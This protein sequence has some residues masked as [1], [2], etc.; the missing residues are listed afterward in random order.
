M[1]LESIAAWE[2]NY[3]DVPFGSTWAL[4][5]EQLFD[6]PD[7][8]PIQHNKIELAG[9]LSLVD[10]P[11]FPTDN[12]TPEDALDFYLTRPMSL[13]GQTIGGSAN[14]TLQFRRDATH[15]TTENDRFVTDTTI[16]SC[17]APNRAVGY[18]IVGTFETSGMDI[19][20][21]W[22]G[23]ELATTGCS[24]HRVDR[25]FDKIDGTTEVDEVDI[26][27]D[28]T[29]FDEEEFLG[30]PFRDG[31]YEKSYGFHDK[32]TVSCT[33]QCDR[34]RCERSRI[35]RECDQVTLALQAVCGTLNDWLIEIVRT[36]EPAPR[37]I[38]ESADCADAVA[39]NSQHGW[40]PFTA[41]TYSDFID[42]EGT[43]PAACEINCY[44]WQ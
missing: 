20:F 30:I 42:C 38:C 14:G 23:S 32:V 31:T 21:V 12:P 43:P 22:P 3:R 36:D 9:E 18:E 19:V 29:G 1:L 15:W 28:M 17:T 27:Y 40:D 37:I 39:A 5:Y 35:L 41:I 16:S 8:D 26:F 13:V 24:V 2:E 44:G 25:T 10:E 6:H 7:D 33:D 34:P 4:T 11:E